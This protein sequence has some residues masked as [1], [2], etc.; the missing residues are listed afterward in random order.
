MS[1]MITS[2][3]PI[4]KSVT[5]ISLNI[6]FCILKSFFTVYTPCM[7]I[8]ISVCVGTCKN[9]TLRKMEIINIS[10]IEFLVLLHL[11]GQSQN[12]IW[13]P[14]LYVVKDVSFL[15]SSFLWTLQKERLYSF[16]QYI[17]LYWTHCESLSKEEFSQ[18]EKTRKIPPSGS[19]P[20]SSEV[21]S[22]LQI[23]WCISSHLGILSCV[24]MC[25]FLYKEYSMFVYMHVH[26]FIC[27]IGITPHEF[28]C[29]M[30]YSTQ[31]N[32]ERSITY[33]DY[34][35]IDAGSPPA[36]GF[37]QPLLLTTGH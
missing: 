20:L 6:Q 17:M 19:F 15:S 35:F 18:S 13:N 24:Y 25:T 28:F 29:D 12:P 3:T 16:T 2:L 14:L 34:E 8:T 10:I 37:I 33:S 26:I 31:C 7:H 21:S 22:A 23:V 9:R 4:S 5:F 11:S 30:F 1:A 27:K 36:W 32:M